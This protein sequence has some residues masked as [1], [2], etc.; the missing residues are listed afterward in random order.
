MTL[1]RRDPGTGLLGMQH[2]RR[3]FGDIAAIRSRLS[4][5]E[6]ATAQPVIR[7][8]AGVPADGDYATTPRD[9]TLVVDSANNRLYVRVG[10]AW[11]YTALT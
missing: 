4:T 1:P 9:G 11:K 3:V 8:K 2:L 6:A 10:G 7:V 5:L